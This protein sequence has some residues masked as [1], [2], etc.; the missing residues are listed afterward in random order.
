MNNEQSKNHWD[1][2]YALKASNEV[3]W[4]QE[5]PQTSLS[6]IKQ[7][8]IQK[9]AKIIDIGGGDSRF[10]DFLIEKGYQNVT[11][12]DISAEAIEKTKNRLGE[13]ASQ[14]HWIVADVTE[15]L[16]ADKYD[17][18]HDR[19][20]FHFL[21]TD[22][23]IEKYLNNARISVTEKGVVTI[24]TFSESGP[25]KCSGLDIK[26]YSE[27]SMTEQL[28][29]GFKKIKCVLEDHN[30]PFSTIQNFIFCSFRRIDKS[31]N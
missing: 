9:T 15:F 11:V 8:K 19:A 1:K 26:Q 21:T 27:K 31:I 29:K 22:E 20:A 23:Q 10:V 2:V 30:T 13:K 17:F 7:Y 12:L 24:G 3:S 4:F 14:V 16:S 5:V 25:K 18:W 28:S 6:F